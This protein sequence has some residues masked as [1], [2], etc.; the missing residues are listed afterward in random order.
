MANGLFGRVLRSLRPKRR[1]AKALHTEGQTGVALVPSAAVR[2]LPMTSATTLPSAL[3]RQTRGLVEMARKDRLSRVSEEQNHSGRP[4]ARPTLSLSGSGV[5]SAQ[6]LDKLAA[7]LAASSTTT[8]S[9]SSPKSSSSSSSSSSSV[10]TMPVK[11]AVEQILALWDAVIY[12]LDAGTY[13]T[14]SS[15]NGPLSNTSTS[16][17]DSMSKRFSSMN[18]FKLSLDSG[19]VGFESAAK[20]LLSAIMDRPELD[21]LLVALANSGGCRSHRSSSRRM[22]RR[23]S[24][25]EHSKRRRSESTGRKHHRR[26]FHRKDKYISDDKNQQPL[27]SLARRYL[28]LHHSTM[29]LLIQERQ[30][31]TGPTST[32][33]RPSALVAAATAKST[34]I[35]DALLLTAIVSSF[36][37]VPCLRESMLNKLQNT[38]PPPQAHQQQ[39]RSASVTRQQR[40][41]RSASRLSMADRT[42]T[43]SQN[44]EDVQVSVFR[45]LETLHPKCYSCIAPLNS[46]D[47]WMPEERF[48][49][50]ILEQ[51]DMETVLV[52]QIVKQLLRNSTGGR[53]EWRNVPG[54][55]VLK[56]SMLT[57]TR[58]QFETQIKR[59]EDA[60]LKEHEDVN[61]ESPKKPSSKQKTAQRNSEIQSAMQESATPSAQFTAHVMTMLATNPE[62]IQDYMMAIFENTNAY[63]P[64]HVSECLKMFETLL[65][66]C[67]MY[68]GNE[69]TSMAPGGSAVADIGVLRHVFTCLVESEHFEII[70]NT[71]LFLL[72]HFNRFSISLQQEMITLFAAQFQ[73]LFL[74]WNRDVRFCYFHV[75]LYLT[76]PGN[77]IVLC[78]KSDESLLG[79]AEA[80]QLFEIPGL[81][82][83]KETN[84][85]QFD[86]PLC[87]AIAVNTR[88]TKARKRKKGGSPPSAQ[89]A[90]PTIPTWADKESVSY[91]ERSVKEYQAL[92]QTYFYYAKQISLH[93]A[94]PTPV[95]Q[96]KSS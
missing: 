35:N 44:M 69:R 58:R 75:L 31:Y 81:V 50:E 70:K 64:H 42:R 9:Q 90:V 55:Q 37:R 18:G 8:S 23:A 54:A 53:I 32:N 88:V 51:K 67:P 59:A 95:F 74:H 56:N 41:S 87:Q 11:A 30:E 33:G 25:V 76:Y 26:L 85:E 24:S 6:S 36:H 84:W 71:L 72:K 48:L 39:T 13:G 77:R 80:S 68:F 46:L 60:M 12:F 83:S 38:L 93:E 96:L 79:S 94:V 3:V 66:A 14:L 40:K 65:V 92:V 45:W 21:W 89:V 29:Q 10:K 15:A 43:L 91:I 63:L 47:G 5:P 27:C 28:E 1:D 49:D 4:S 61:E 52:V 73:R 7:L 16:S 20:R 78:A 2:P 34:D 62:F 82:R 19:S 22:S 17:H 57:I 86:E